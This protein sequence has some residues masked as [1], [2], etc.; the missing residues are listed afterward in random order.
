MSRVTWARVCAG[1]AA[2]AVVLVL[3]AGGPS[4]WRDF[5]G[6][7]NRVAVDGGDGGALP[8][9]EPLEQGLHPDALAAASRIASPALLLVARRGHLVHVHPS[10]DAAA[11]PRAV[12]LLSRLALLAT[13][14]ATADVSLADGAEPLQQRLAALD[15]WSR[16]AAGSGSPRN[17]W[18]SRARALHGPAPEPPRSLVELHGA[19]P[20]LLA[21]ALWKPLGAAAASYAADGAG[22]PRL[23]C[24]LGMRPLDGLALASA[25]Q[26][27]G[28]VAGTVLMDAA[29]ARAVLT[30][31]EDG[32]PPRGAEPFGAR[33]VT[34]LRDEQGSRLYFF[35]AQELVILLLGADEARL[36][37]ETALAHEILRGIVDNLPRPDG[38]PAIVVPLH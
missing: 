38:G 30:A 12:P 26:A 34:L 15:A 29:R 20:S 19:V 1:V 35:P 11:E 28:R 24:C 3:C 36:E 14:A 37:D 5:L 32:R 10:F 4:Y 18:S 8:R 31:M 13:V 21:D 2:G 6:H 23:H 17:P 7:G 9:A 25:L 33:K 16:E 22:Q 27:G